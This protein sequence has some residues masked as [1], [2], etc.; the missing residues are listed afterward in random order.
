MVE[1]GAQRVIRFVKGKRTERSQVDA[2]H[3]TAALC[4]RGVA[5][6]AE[7]ETDESWLIADPPGSGLGGRWLSL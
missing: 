2:E 6:L 4:Q 5:Q 1:G 7:S 3:L